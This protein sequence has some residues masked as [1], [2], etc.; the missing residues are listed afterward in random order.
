M[1]RAA[2]IYDAV[3]T[4]RG[5]GKNSGSLHEVKPVDL[6]A[7]LLK[8]IQLR[9]SLDTSRVDDFVAGCNHPVLEEGCNIAR[10][11]VLAAGW[12]QS[13]PGV[14]IERHCDQH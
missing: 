6:M 8:A 10:T 1:S 5:K 14:Q 13:I 12:D 3:R 9:N 7:G 11:A 2:F 4:P